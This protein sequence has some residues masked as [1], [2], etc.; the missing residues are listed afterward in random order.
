MPAQEALLTNDDLS[1]CCSVVLVQ[2]GDMWQVYT[3][4]Y[5]T[6]HDVA[7]HHPAILRKG[8]KVHIEDC[9][10]EQQGGRAML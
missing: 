4:Y 1:F 3:T 9:Y 2:V 10:A 8:G 6:Y 5:T 7:L